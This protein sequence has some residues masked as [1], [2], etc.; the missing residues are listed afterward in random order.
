MRHSSALLCLLM[1]HRESARSISSRYGREHRT[2]ARDCGFSAKLP[3]GVFQRPPSRLAHVQIYLH[4]PRTVYCSAGR[5][6]ALQLLASC[7]HSHF[8]PDAN[9]QGIAR[10]MATLRARAAAARAG[11]GQPLT[12]LITGA[13]SGIGFTLAIQLA[14]A[15]VRVIL[16][17]RNR[18]R[19]EE[20]VR[21][22]KAAA[23][24]ADV[25]LLLIDVADG[26]SVLSAVQR[27]KI[28]TALGA[29]HIDL[30]YLN[31]G[32]MPVNRNRWEIAVW[33]FFTGKLPLFLETG[34]ASANGKHFLQQ[35]LD[36]AG[37][38][39]APSLLATHV[40]G[41]VLLAEEAAALMGHLVP[42]DDRKGRII[43]TGSRA[44]CTAYVNWPLL[45]PPAC[46]G[47]KSAFVAACSAPGGISWPGESYGEAKRI[48][49]LVSVRR[50]ANA[51]T[52]RLVF[53]SA[54]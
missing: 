19:G 12:A 23:A 27:C 39:G 25:R 48:V 47:D 49:D 35:P 13:N 8:Q 3:P 29:T 46:V 42:G 44:A 52:S 41:H 37:Y 21:R 17:C 6:V 38:C 43:W 50:D 32:I 16:G 34:R 7:L 14:R 20:A 4:V 1:L 5:R 15:G 30:L 24:G 36:D 28:D 18:G 45:Q 2:T 51:A 33:A 26:A 31:A 54:K 10:D 22:V 11:G 9:P 40:L 53:R